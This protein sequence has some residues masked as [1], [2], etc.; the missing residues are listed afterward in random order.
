MS[1]EAAPHHMHHRHSSPAVSPYEDMK[2]SLTVPSAY[3]NTARLSYP[4]SGNSGG[5][6]VSPADMMWGGV[7]NPAFIAS[8]QQSL[9]SPQQSLSKS[10]WYHEI[11]AGYSHSFM[12]RTEIMHTYL[13]P[14]LTQEQ[15]GVVHYASPPSKEKLTVTIPQKEGG[16]SLKRTTS[17]DDMFG[18]MSLANSGVG[19][20]LLDTL[21]LASSLTYASPRLSIGLPKTPSHTGLPPDI[22]MYIKTPHQIMPMPQFP[23]FGAAPS[24]LNSEYEKMAKHQVQSFNNNNQ[25]ATAPS[26]GHYMYPSPRQPGLS[27]PLAMI[28]AS[29]I[30][31]GYSQPKFRMKRSNSESDLLDCKKFESGYM[32]MHGRANN[33]FAGYMDMEKSHLAKLK[34]EAKKKAQDNKGS[35]SNQST[36]SSPSQWQV[37]QDIA[38]IAS[39]HLTER[40]M[41]QSL[42]IFATTHRKKSGGFKMPRLFRSQKG[43]KASDDDARSGSG[44]PSQTP[45]KYKKSPSQALIGRMKQGKKDRK[46]SRSRSETDLQD[47]GSVDAGYMDMRK[48]SFGFKS[49]MKRANSEFDLLD[50]NVSNASGDSIQSEPADRIVYSYRKKFQSGD[51]NLPLPMHVPIGSYKD[52]NSQ[53]IRP[54]S[55]SGP[56]TAPTRR[57]F[58]LKMFRQSSKSKDIS[59]NVSSTESSPDLSRSSRFQEASPPKQASPPKPAPKPK[60]S[61]LKIPKKSFSSESGIVASDSHK[62]FTKRKSIDKPDDSSKSTFYLSE[63]HETVTELSHRPLPTLPRGAAPLNGESEVPVDTT[64]YPRVKPPTPVRPVPAPPTQTAP[65]RDYQQINAKQLQMQQQQANQVPDSQF[66]EEYIP[67]GERLRSSLSS[68]GGGSLL[69]GDGVIPAELASR[70]VPI[71][72]EDE[73][74]FVFVDRNVPSHETLHQQQPSSKFSSLV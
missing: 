19:S 72:T 10:P 51:Q 45:R 6:S 62:S 42:Q 14:R 29:A 71:P 24:E 30:P 47:I 60:L 33:M 25:G 58:P 70:P 63:D 17:F 53:A 23:Q 41:E 50:D 57:K 61:K 40:E 8:P 35:A 48:A 15:R 27:A 54:A 12:P 64:R 43:D 34:A 11:R 67:T 65:S 55:H 66:I 31:V 69:S 39:Q 20:P 73:D 46:M 21:D 18:R 4:S 2:N 68:T 1:H 7:S 3:E 16:N 74:D 9:T 32:T 37:P 38:D 5:I 36:S 52:T 59:P 44:S 26:F 13:D 56:A 49:Q 28:G 22:N